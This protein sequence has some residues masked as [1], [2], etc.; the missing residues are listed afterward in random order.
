MQKVRHQVSKQEINALVATATREC[1]INLIPWYF[2]I[3]KVILFIVAFFF[4]VIIVGILVAGKLLLMVLHL[5]AAHQRRVKL[6]GV[7]V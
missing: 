1:V 5:V 2:L 7:S 4:S 6:L 3:T